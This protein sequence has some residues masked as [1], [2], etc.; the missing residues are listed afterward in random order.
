MTNSPYY[1]Y[2]LE[3]GLDSSDLKER[4]YA[5]FGPNSE[6]ESDVVKEYTW[7]GGGYR[8]FSFKCLYGSCLV[9]CSELW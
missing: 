5:F 8:I 2:F 4:T 7:K 1:N 6:Y 3:S 9:N